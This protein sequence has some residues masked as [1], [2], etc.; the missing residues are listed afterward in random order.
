[1]ETPSEFLLALLLDVLLLITAM[2]WRAGV[3]QTRQS[4][5]RTVKWRMTGRAQAA[6]LNEHELYSSFQTCSPLY[7]C[8]GMKRWTGAS[9]R[10][11]NERVFSGMA[12]HLGEEEKKTRGKKTS[13]IA[14]LA[15]RWAAVVE[16]AGSGA[17]CQHI[18]MSSPFRHTLENA[19]SFRAWPG[20]RSEN[21]PPPIR[22]N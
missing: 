14:L 22:G 9:I 19:T 10:I 5:E 2:F 12:L 21:G 1:M 11:N 6:Q 8:F 15:G 20:K 17:W 16:N 18:H 4:V 7:W 13:T 3:Q